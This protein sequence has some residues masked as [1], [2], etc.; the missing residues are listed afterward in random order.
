MLVEEWQLRLRGQA[1]KIF[2]FVP[3]DVRASDRGFSVISALYL[4]NYEH[5]LL[6]WRDCY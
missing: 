2:C 5:K 6:F 1:Y 4:E 3:S